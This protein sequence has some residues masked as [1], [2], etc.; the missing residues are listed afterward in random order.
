MGRRQDGKG[1]DGQEATAETCAQLEE[2]VQTNQMSPLNKFQGPG[3]AGRVKTVSILQDANLR[4]LPATQDS[5]HR[6]RTKA[7]HA[8]IDLVDQILSIK[9]VKILSLEDVKSF[10][11]T[12]MRLF[13][14]MLVYV[15]DKIPC[16]KIIPTAPI[17]RLGLERT[18]HEQDLQGH[19]CFL[20]SRHQ[21]L[22]RHPTTFHPH[23]PVHG[24]IPFRPFQAICALQ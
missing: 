1:V 16:L 7:V 11:E 21:R 17:S 2:R 14:I 3:R 9:Y 22:T 23:I 15:V 19:L 18:R 6:S 24:P 12:K 13:F 10:S 20:P 5:G 4:L 8:D